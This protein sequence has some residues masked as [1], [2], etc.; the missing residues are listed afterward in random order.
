MPACPAVKATERA[1]AQREV[2]EEEA[3]DAAR[4][5]E[6]G[7]PRREAAALLV[8]RAAALLAPAMKVRTAAP[9]CC[10]AAEAAAFAGFAPR[11]AA[12]CAKRSIVVGAVCRGDECSRDR[13]SAGRDLA[14]LAGRAQCKHSAQGGTERDTLRGN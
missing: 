1:A 6:R 3:A 4:R 13:V 8:R 11:V 12:V 10:V 9:C 14:S 5:E 7:A 2:L